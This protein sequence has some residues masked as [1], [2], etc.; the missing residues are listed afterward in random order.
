MSHTVTCKVEMRDENSL[1]RAIDHLNLP[2]V[3]GGRIG[4][5]KLY[6]GQSAHGIAIQLPNWRH[7]VVIDPVTGTAKYDNFNGSWGK[8]IELDKLVQ[9][10]SIER[11]MEEAQ[12]VGYN[13]EEN[14][15]ENGDV[16]LVMTQVAST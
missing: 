4:T 15:L 3:E 10:Y 6:G 13:V 14:T 7:P 16:E 9:R 5:H 11:T 12:V 1:R 8:Q 2:L